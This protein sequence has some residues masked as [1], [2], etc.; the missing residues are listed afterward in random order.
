MYTIRILPES[1]HDVLY[2]GCRVMADN[3]QHVYIILL[4]SSY[5]TSHYL[6]DLR[7]L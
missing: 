4:Y 7:Q 1:L 6:P 3:I 5:S 2:A